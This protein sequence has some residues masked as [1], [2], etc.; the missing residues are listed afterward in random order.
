MMKILFIFI[1]FLSKHSLGVEIVCPREIKSEQS[2][3]G[4]TTDGWENFD[5]HPQFSHKLQ[6]LEVFSGPPKEDANLV[7]DNEKEPYY[8]TI[9]KNNKNG[10]WISCKYMD[11]RISLV[12]KIPSKVS[13]CV[14][15]Y[16]EKHKSGDYLD[17]K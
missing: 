5:Y 17:C 11:T 15:K 16:K 3:V 12:K 13:K 4:T 6:R 2:I 14:Y 9:S 10:Y 8:W 1:L 7:P